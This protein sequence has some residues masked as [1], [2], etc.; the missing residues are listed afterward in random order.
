MKRYLE[1]RFYIFAGCLVGSIIGIILMDAYLQMNTTLFEVTMSALFLAPVVTLLMSIL[2][3]LYFLF[4][5]KGKLKLVP[6]VYKA[7]YIFGWR[8]DHTRS[9]LRRSVLSEECKDEDDY[10]NLR[11]EMKI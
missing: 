1:I 6:L 2:E 8:M 5:T 4:L 7:V 9:L 11:R 10:L 3:A